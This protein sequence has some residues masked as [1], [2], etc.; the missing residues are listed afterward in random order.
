MIWVNEVTQFFFKFCQTSWRCKLL[1]RILTFHRQT[2][3]HIDT[4]LPL[5]VDRKGLKAGR[6]LPK[7]PF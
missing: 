1:R 2:E 3:S 7:K 6:K 4:N 5:L